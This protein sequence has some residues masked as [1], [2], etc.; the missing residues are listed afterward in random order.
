MS[1]SRK[2]FLRELIKQH[3]PALLNT[4]VQD[5]A[6]EMRITLDEA[7]SLAKQL[8]EDGYLQTVGLGGNIVPTERG[9]KAAEDPNWD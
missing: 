2:Q 7:E 1:S 9:R 3:N 5:V 4:D 8:E 6:H